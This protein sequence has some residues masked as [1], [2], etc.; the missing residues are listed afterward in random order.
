MKE[1]LEKQDRTQA[2]ATAKPNGLYLVGVKYPDEFTLPTPSNGPIF[3]N[4]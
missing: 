3:Y 2:A 1:L 4:A